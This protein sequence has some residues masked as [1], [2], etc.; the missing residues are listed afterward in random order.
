MVVGTAVLL[1]G[2][3]TATDQGAGVDPTLQPAASLTA[4]ENTTTDARSDPTATD[5]PAT[6]TVQPE[7]GA[8]GAPEQAPSR[9]D[10]DLSLPDLSLAKLSLEQVASVDTPTA[11]AVRPGDPGLYVA[12]RAGRVVV[13]G[14]DG[15]VSEP[16]LDISGSTATTSE[17]GLLGL[18]WS[19]DGDTLY[20]SSSD[21]EGATRLES[22]DV[23]DDV[24]QAG[25]RTEL[26]RVA[27]PA[28]NHNGGNI[29]IGPD[30]ML[31]LALGD[32]GAANDQFGNGQQPDT[33]LGAM[34]RIDPSGGDP[35]GIPEDNPFANGGEG[36]PEV[37]AYGLRNPWRFSF[38]AATDQLWIADVGQNEIEEI[39]R[40]P[41]TQAGLNFGWPR[42][43]GNQP[44]DGQPAEGPVVAPVHTYTHARGCSIT[45]GYVYRGQAI[46]ELQGAYIYTDFCNGTIYALALDAEGQV[47]QD[48]DTGLEVEQPVS[49]GQGPDGELYVLSLT[50][51][52]FRIIEG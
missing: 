13:I 46:P 42:F 51:D 14:S 28:S 50:G 12:E 37:W 33:L 3:V 8:T 47:A 45:G 2:C 36:A 23:V 22:F 21:S 19:P 38:D 34:L 40:V 15:N 4:G 27:Q 6:D 26:L 1:T 11:L 43:E 17:R 41:A 7:T 49:F 39:D 29:A 10:S 35:Y 18:V 52:I 30:G 32:G 24:V 48:V 31:W 16:I 44:F 20:L 25:S 9:S 5:S